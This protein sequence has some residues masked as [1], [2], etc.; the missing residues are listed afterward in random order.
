MDITFIH[1]WSY[2]PHVWKNLTPYFSGHTLHFIDLGYTKGYDGPHTNDIPENSVI[3]C[4]SFG[5]M[6]A[7]KNMLAPRA[8]V[9]IA[10]FYNYLDFWPKPFFLMLKSGLH[11]FPNKALASFRHMC[12][13]KDPLPEYNLDALNAGLNDIIAW[14][15]KEKALSL[16]IP[17]MALA[18]KNDLVV[19]APLTKSQWEGRDL[20]LRWI[21]DG[22]H[23]LPIT[24]AQW[25]AQNIE[26]FISAL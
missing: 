3:I 22:G 5:T 21:K 18:S 11:T 19:P 12:R 6:W 2:D 4:H 8:L 10:G 25:C 14:D 15:L 24:R 16:N 1:G 17:F 9:S 20:D 13:D 26:E 7:L 23:M